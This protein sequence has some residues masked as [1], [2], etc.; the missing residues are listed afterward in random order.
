MQTFSASLGA[1]VLHE[2]TRLILT[3]RRKVSVVDEAAR[4]DCA[5]RTAQVR[6]VA[7]EL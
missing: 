3:E 4:A 2:P 5:K 7:D 6:P 1:A